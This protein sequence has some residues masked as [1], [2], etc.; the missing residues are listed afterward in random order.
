MR[1]HFRSL[2]IHFYINSEEKFTA[3][4]KEAKKILLEKRITMLKARVDLL[5]EVQ[6]KIDLKKVH[7]ST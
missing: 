5:V 6:R 3:V 4:E 2:Y 1:I 7:H